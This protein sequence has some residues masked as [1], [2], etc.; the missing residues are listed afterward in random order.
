MH[1]LASPKG[2][3]SGSLQKQLFLLARCHWDVLRGGNEM[4]NVP[5]GHE[6]GETAVFTGHN[7]P[8]RTIFSRDNG[9][10]KKFF[11]LKEKRS[12]SSL[13]I[14]TIA[15]VHERFMFLL[16]LATASYSRLKNTNIAPSWWFKCLLSNLETNPTDVAKG[17]LRVNFRERVRNQS[18]ISSWEHETRGKSWDKQ[19]SCLTCQV[20]M[21]YI[22]S[23]CKALMNHCT[24]YSGKE[25]NIKPNWFLIQV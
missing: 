9:W 2:K 12:P 11:F 20:C 4:Q 14:Q 22:V 15:G 7:L 19:K 1:L 21:R 3:R 18:V 23:S 13:R 6:W 25:H 24:F 17:F 10:S 5:S 16:T 8:S